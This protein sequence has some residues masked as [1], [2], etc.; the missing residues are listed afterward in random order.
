MPTNNRR[1]VG[2][3]KPILLIPQFLFPVLKTTHPFLILSESD[4]S[5]SFLGNREENLEEN[6]EEN[7]RLT[8]RI[9]RSI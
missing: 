9:D 8:S 6:L 1:K 5:E 7:P 2:D 3:L 4:H